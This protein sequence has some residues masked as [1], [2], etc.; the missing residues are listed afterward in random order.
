MVDEARVVIADDPHP[1]DPRGH[2]GQQVARRGGQAVAA[3]AV[4]ER[5]AEAIEARDAAAVDVALK[6][7]QRGVAVIRGQEL[8]EARE[9]AGFFEVQVGDQQRALGGPVKRAIGAGEEIVTGERKGNHGAALTPKPPLIQVVRQMIAK[10][11]RVV[12]RIVRD[13]AVGGAG[14]IVERLEPQGERA[15]RRASARGR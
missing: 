10:R 1:V 8:A 14:K 15:G 3:E 2:R 6:R 13:L 5:V 7:G 4:M 12:E 11:A 9:P